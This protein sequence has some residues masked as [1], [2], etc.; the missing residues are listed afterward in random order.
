[1]AWRG[2]QA[3]VFGAGPLALAWQE[4]LRYTGAQRGYHGGASVQEVVTPLLVL[5]RRSHQDLR[6]GG[7]FQALPTSAPGWWRW[8]GACEAPAPRTAAAAL[9]LERAPQ[10]APA[11]VEA[12]LEH[13]LYKAQVR[14]GLEAEQVRR[15][16]SPL[17]RAGARWEVHLSEV[18][19]ALELPEGL[20]RPMVEGLCSRLE[21]DGA[22]LLWLDRM[23]E[24]LKLE[25]SVLRSRFGLDPG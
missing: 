21:L 11:W 7:R 8:E 10:E 23:D 13:P 3:S 4:G 9:L 16:L 15:L 2:A 18:A 19:R 25:V 20:T 5:T 1:V 17:R 12:L 22:R 14:G 24:R 6:A